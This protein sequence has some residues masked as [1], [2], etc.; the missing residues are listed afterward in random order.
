MYHVHRNVL[1]QL[2]PNPPNDDIDFPSTF[3]VYPVTGVDGRIGSE[4]ALTVSIAL[5][6]SC[7]SVQDSRWR[8]EF[9]TYVGYSL[10]IHEFCKVLTSCLIRDRLQV[11]L[12]LPSVEY[13]TWLGRPDQ[14]LD[15]FQECRGVGSAQI[16]DAGGLPVETDLSHL[17]A[18]PFENFDEIL[19]RARGYQDRAR[20]QIARRHY[21][22]VLG[23]LSRARD[24]FIWWSKQDIEL[25]NETEAKWTEFWDIKLETSLLC[26][27]Q[28]LRRG[29]WG[30]AR[31]E[32]IEVFETFP[33]K[34]ES[35]S[36]PRRLWD[37]VSECHYF[38]GLS[39]LLED[40]KVCGKVCA[41]QSFLKALISKPGHEQVDNEIDK[42][43][44]A[45]ENSDYPADEIARWN[46]KHVLERFRHQPLLDS[47][48]DA[49]NHGHRGPASMT[50][51]ELSAL[52]RKFVN[53]LAC[54]P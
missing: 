7:D 9:D 2:R 33:L 48:L 30:R 10:H 54:R 4:P 5:Q 41:L 25:S 24:F 1:G 19:N 11:R 47:S 18:K 44:A 6:H 52:R 34:L 32:I 37:N 14:I 13:H 26:A 36:V 22:D 28:L 8:D 46:I 17:M 40:R 27:S 16:F 53:F 49:D 38:M 42:I 23:T 21:S 51:D 3:S 50:E 15:C 39:Y 29:N 12:S 35:A 45:I 31:E 43:E 20:Q